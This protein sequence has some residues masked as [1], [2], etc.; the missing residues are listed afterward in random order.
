M[1][2]KSHEVMRIDSTKLLYV[3]QVIQ[4]IS[5]CLR[6]TPIYVILDFSAMRN[7]WEFDDQ[8]V[9]GSTMTLL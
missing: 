7:K 2:R 3:A 1:D 4:L 9:I 6:A 8:W 5:Y